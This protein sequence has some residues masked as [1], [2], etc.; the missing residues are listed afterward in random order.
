MYYK[1]PVHSVGLIHSRLH[2][3]LIK[4]S[5]CHEAHVSSVVGCLKV[6]HFLIF[7]MNTR[8]KFY[9]NING[10]NFYFSLFSLTAF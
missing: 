2:R 8:F 10:L 3:H 1:D 7:K 4:E 6:I 5:L 9:T